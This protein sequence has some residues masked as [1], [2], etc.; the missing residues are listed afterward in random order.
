MEGLLD[1]ERENAKKQL[2]LP[3]QSGDVGSPPPPNQKDPWEQL[4]EYGLNDQDLVTIRRAADKDPHFSVDRVVDN[5]RFLSE[6]NIAIKG[7]T[8]Q[9]M[10]ERQVSA[11]Q[12]Y[13]LHSMKTVSQVF[14]TADG[15]Y[16]LV[17]G[18]R[19]VAIVTD[20]NGVVVSTWVKEQ[21]TSAIRGATPIFSSDLP[22]LAAGGG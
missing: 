2:H 1:F 13:D 8:L 6:R 21:I 22:W 17:N 12:I 18:G 16:M 9:R 3:D 19:S 14:Q 10:A 5:V 11:Q 4:R 7:H 20:S 15:N